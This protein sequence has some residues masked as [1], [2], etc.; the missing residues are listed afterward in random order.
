LQLQ[1]VIQR[2]TLQWVAVEQAVLL[3]A[4]VQM[5]LLLQL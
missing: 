5:V 4:K 1:A 3:A 2:L